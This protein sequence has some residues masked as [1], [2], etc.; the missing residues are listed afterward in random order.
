[1]AETLKKYDIVIMGATGFTGK[2]IAAYLS[3]HA[4]RESIRWAIAGRNESKLHEL[5]D[6]LSGV[7]PEILIADVNKPASIQDMCR[8]ARIVM[9]A[10]GPFNLYGRTVVDACIACEAQY[11]DITGEPS[12]VAEIYN[13]CHAKAEAAGVCVVNCCGFDS[14]PADY[15]VYLT[16]QKLP[17]S[18][19]KVVKGYMRTNARFSGGTLTTAVHA[20]YLESLGKS[21]KTVIPKNKVAPRIKKQIHYNSDLKGW[22]IPMPVVDPHIVKRSAFRLSDVYG[23]VTYVQ[24]FV[25][26]SF[27]KVVSTVFPIVVAMLMIR[28]AF[29]RKWL[30][31]KFPSGSGP[32]DKTRSSSRFEVTFFGQAGKDR[33]KTIISGGD[34]GYTET[35]KMFS[36]C[37]FVMLSKLRTKTLTPGVLTPVEAFGMDLVDRLEKEGISF[38]VND[39]K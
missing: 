38:V 5:Q 15:G 27:S 28:F 8:Q 21:V 36:Q 10:A 29:F 16:V 34:P 11:L 26:T 39:S 25:R 4:H 32:D 35:A 13:D 1:M 20:L 31:S 37:A 22:G 23:P 17:V 9:N 2:L 7:K 14:I 24:Y 18:L 33:A 12:F 3:E 6:R 30:F 19:P